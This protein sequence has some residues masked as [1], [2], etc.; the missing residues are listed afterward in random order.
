MISSDRILVVDVESNRI[1]IKQLTIN[2][3]VPHTNKLT[4]HTKITEVNFSE[5]VY[6]LFHGDFSPRIGTNLNYMTHR[7]QYTYTY[8]YIQRIRTMHTSNTITKSHKTSQGKVS[9]LCAV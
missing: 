7:I 2:H 3:T 5:F 9:R 6:S 4:E 1:F 8:L